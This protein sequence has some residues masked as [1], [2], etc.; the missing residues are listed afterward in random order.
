MKVIYVFCLF[1]TI[2]LS[3]QKIIWKEG[4]KLNWNNF[5]SPINKKNNTDI[6]AYTNCG[7]EYSVIKSSNPKSPVTF[8][9]RATFTENKS[10]KDVKK[11]NDH[12]LLHE[13]KHFDIAELFV[14]KFRKVV[15]EKIKTSG[16]YDRL[17]KTIYNTI[18]NDYKNFQMS[19]DKD[20][21]HG[22]DTEKQ[23]EYN[24]A[25]SEELENLKSY[26]AP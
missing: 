26:K 9:I 12:I 2:V 18:S 16:D 25:V 22:M 17:F 5:K 13:Q 20:T 24:T 7:W 21:R 6:A 10:W 19:Y 23:A 14:R 3:G 8:E 4:E 1:S 11:I 15:A